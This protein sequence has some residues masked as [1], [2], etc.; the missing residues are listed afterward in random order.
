MEEELKYKYKYPH[1]AVAADCAIF[2]FDGRKVQI[3]LIKRGNYP[4]EGFWAVPGGFVNMDETTESAAI[5]ELK[6]ETGGTGEN[7][8]L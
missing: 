8:E 2:G 4:Y 7:V 3:L 6:E 1:P 5:R